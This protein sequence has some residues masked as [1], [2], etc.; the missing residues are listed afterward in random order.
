MSCPAPKDDS[1]G[2]DEEEV[3]SSSL[4]RMEYFK[5]RLMEIGYKCFMRKGFGE[6]IEAA[7]GALK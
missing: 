2:P 7:C 6:D 3:K 4:E 1:V 5:E